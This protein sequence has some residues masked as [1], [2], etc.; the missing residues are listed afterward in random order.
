MSDFG[1]CSADH[2]KCGDVNGKSKGICVP[3]AEPCPI[4]DLV[5]AVANPDAGRFDESLSSGTGFSAFF[6]RGQVGQPLVE[7]DMKEI[8]PCY[9]PDIIPITPDRAPYVLSIR[10]EDNACRKDERWVKLDFMSYGR[11]D[12]YDLN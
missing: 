9:Q 12:T 2:K 8:G 5:F 3:S 4:T 6:T 10:R 7:T 1:E 11:K